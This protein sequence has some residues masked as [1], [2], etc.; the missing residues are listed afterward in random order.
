[1]WHAWERGEIC[2]GFWLESPKGGDHLEDQGIDVRMGLKWILGR[3]AG[4]GRDVEWIQLAEDRN[5]WWAVVNAVQPIYERRTE[6]VT[7]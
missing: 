6:N 5:R 4:G 1:M 3:L 2:T 7:T